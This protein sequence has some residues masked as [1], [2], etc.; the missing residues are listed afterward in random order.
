MISTIRLTSFMAARTSRHS[1]MKVSPENNFQLGLRSIMS[2]RL[3]FGLSHSISYFHFTYFNF[4]LLLF[5]YHCLIKD[6]CVF[7]DFFFELFFFA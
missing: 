1:S 2:R 6:L 5:I 3:Y 7:F 4:P